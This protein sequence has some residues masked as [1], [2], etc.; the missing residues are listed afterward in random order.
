M[1]RSSD[2]EPN[3]DWIGDKALENKQG[4]YI[5]AEEMNNSI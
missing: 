2:N 4:T 1:E 3:R 5:K